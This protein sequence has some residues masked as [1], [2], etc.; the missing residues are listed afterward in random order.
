MY[1]LNMSIVMHVCCLALSINLHLPAGGE[2]Q[3]QCRV[4][5]VGVGADVQPVVELGLEGAGGTTEVALTPTQ[6]HTLVHG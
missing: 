4:A 5:G 2:V 3:W 6:L 1:T